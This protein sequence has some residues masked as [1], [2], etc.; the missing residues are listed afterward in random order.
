MKPERRRKTL[1]KIV[2]RIET[3]IPDATAIMTLK[4]VT[5][6]ALRCVVKDPISIF[7]TGVVSQG[8]KDPV[9]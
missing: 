9:D 1:V 4:A 5:C 8:G 6:G 7:L 2:Q 3:D